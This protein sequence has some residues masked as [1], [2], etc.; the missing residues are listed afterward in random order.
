MK[1][2]IPTDENYAS[3]DASKEQQDQLLIMFYTV[4]KKVIQMCKLIEM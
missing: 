1:E 3:V 4:L 2:D